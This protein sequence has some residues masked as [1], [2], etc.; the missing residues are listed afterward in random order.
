MSQEPKASKGIDPEMLAAYIDKKLPPEQR[1]IVEAQLATDPDSYTVLV[2]S[3]RALDEIGTDAT[4]VPKAPEVKVVPMVQKAKA[5]RTRWVIAG[6]SLAAAAAIVLA[7]M[8][9]DFLQRYLG[10]DVDPQFE[11]LVAAVGEERYT[12]ARL[13][14]GFK[15]GPMRSATRDAGSIAGQNLELLAAAGEA[16]KVANTERNAA[17]LH[18]WGVAQVILGDY[19]G[20]ISALSDSV[21]LAPNAQRLSDL[22]AALLTRG[23]RTNSAVDIP[24]A[25]AQA[26]RALVANPDLLEARFN[27]ALALR[28]LRLDQAADEAWED[29]RHRDPSRW[30]EAAEQRKPVSRATPSPDQVLQVIL[31]KGTSVPREII[32]RSPEAAMRAAEDLL[33]MKWADAVVRNDVSAQQIAK[34]TLSIGTEIL[35]ISGDAL[36]RDLAQ[37]LGD[38]PPVEAQAVAS[39]LLRYYE[40]QR[41]L[42][43]YQF[44]DAASKLAAVTREMESHHNPMAAIAWVALSGALRSARDIPGSAAALRDGSAIVS[45]YPCLEARATRTRGLVDVG[46]GNYPSALDSYQRAIDRFRMCGMRLLEAQGATLSAEILTLLGSDDAWDYELIATGA[47]DH[48]ATPRD[49]QPVYYVGGA[50]ALASNL[51]EVAVHFFSAMVQCAEQVGAPAAIAEARLNRAKAYLAAGFDDALRADIAEVERVLPTSPAGEHSEFVRGGWRAIEAAFLAEREP[52]AA[53]RAADEAD[54]IVR[55]HAQGELLPRILLAKGLA[56][57]KLGRIAESIAVLRAGIQELE[58]RLGQMTDPQLRLTLIE[59]SWQ[60]Y[61]ELAETLVSAGSTTEA[62]QVVERSIGR[63][64]GSDL[65]AVTSVESIQ[66]SIRPQAALLYLLPVR[67]R[68][69]IWVLTRTGVSFAS[70]DLVLPA[71]NGASDLRHWAAQR[72]AASELIRPVAGMLSNTNAIGLIVTGQL[73]LAPWAAVPLPSGELLGERRT[74]LLLPNGSFVS[75]TTRSASRNQALVVGA[76]LMPKRG[77]NQ[78]P[79]LPFASTEGARVAALYPGAILH[80][81]GAATS[82]RVLADI[83]RADVFHF[84]GHSVANSRRPELSRLVVGNGETVFARDLAKAARSRL[85]VAVLSACGTAAG[86]LAAS[87]GSLSIAR[88]LLSA[89]VD[90]VVG[91]QRPVRDD[92]AARFSVELHG[93]LAQGSPVAVAVQKAS[94]MLKNEGVATED[95]SAF[96]SVGGVQDVLLNEEKSR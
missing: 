7:V 61:S 20:G 13:T 58:Q 71:A 14:G 83:G 33:P 67:D 19:D 89:G 22:A 50:L 48:F 6:G 47:V 11:R 39:S 42:R 79:D 56:E 36:W 90:A 23:I 38:V 85:R 35:E 55:R 60:L 45:R 44:R 75:K 93:Y 49:L 86:T 24:Q 43:S 72:A 12:E 54:V 88:E 69:L 16:Q 78:L 2:E 76:S 66:R 87:E 52:E 27:R 17:N 15:F 1:A 5:S 77:L 64:H 91:S 18:V 95:W 34:A 81:D 46:E 73:A 31:E 28:L 32:Q 21:A 63:A 4:E 68:T 29:Y 41:L 37:F 30:S 3:M 51:P 57:R 62:L 65:D 74:L 10:S 92:I 94:L 80:T 84:A 9:P 82:E 25:L 53:I 40:A 96:V 26:E 70:A 8:Q 59:A